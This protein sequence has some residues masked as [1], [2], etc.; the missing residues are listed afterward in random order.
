MKKKFRKTIKK[1]FFSNFYFYS[2]LG[3]VKVVI[4]LLEEVIFDR[5]SRV[6]G[7]LIN[8]LSCSSFFSAA[9]KVHIPDSIS[10]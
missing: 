9:R 2:Y 5:R 7:R 10:I 8:K 4:V 3:I 6:E 1:N